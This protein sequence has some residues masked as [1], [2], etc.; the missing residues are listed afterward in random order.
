MILTVF[1][2]G[3]LV[4]VLIGTPIGVSMILSSLG[5]F[6]WKGTGLNFAAQRMVDGLNSFP[7]IAVPLFILAANLFNASGI[8]HHLFGFAN[9][10][11]GHIRGGMGHVNILAS[12]FFSGMSGSALADAGGL[13]KVEAE[14][15]HKV[16]YPSELAAALTSVSA[17]LGPLVP[18]SIPMVVY[19]VVSGASIGGLFLGG[20]VPGLLCTAAMMAM[21]YVVAGRRKLPVE[22]RKSA[23]EVG[24]LFV[25]SFP[26]L[27][28]PVVI[29]GGIFSGFFSPTEAAAVTVVYAAL[30]S[31]F[32]YREMSWHRFWTCVYDTATM[33]ATIALII[34]GVSMMGVVLAMEKA[35]DQLAAMF[36]QMASG[37]TEFIVL[38]CLLLLIL[39]C[40]IEV[41]ALLLV[42]VP[43]LVPVAMS[44]GVDPVHFGVVVIFTLMLG[45]LTPPMGMVLFVVAQSHGIPIHRLA[46]AVLPWMIPLLA[47]LALMIFVPATVTALP[48]LFL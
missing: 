3:W 13:G 2:L 27:L 24:R 10:L 6:V 32:V 23:A 20:I 28:T 19:G 26:A 21:L 40:F 42:L 4:L 35:P 29:I 14:A 38:V 25:H 43:S 1:I 12:L 17:I 37:P 44:F 41:L 33:S 36:T 11:V 48:S 39:G 8:T 46:V 5:Y 22:T 31:R 47:V 30:V 9:S 18:P 45:T 16:G 15:M 34:G 7:I